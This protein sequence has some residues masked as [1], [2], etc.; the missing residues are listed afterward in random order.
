[1]LVG[2]DVDAIRQRNLVSDHDA[3]AVID[4]HVAMDGDVVAHDELVAEG[5]LQAGENAGILAAVPCFRR[6]TTAG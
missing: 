4:M 5:D 3:S 1:V 2:E 6:K